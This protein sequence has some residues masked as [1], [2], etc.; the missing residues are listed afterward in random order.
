MWAD[1]VVGTALREM[2]GI[3]VLKSLGGRFISEG[4]T[5]GG[6]RKDIGKK[7]CVSCLVVFCFRF[8]CVC[9]FFCFLFFFFAK[10]R[11]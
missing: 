4:Q 5:N 7:L 2:S 1:F 3:V 11:Y 10:K 8:F 9:V 6:V